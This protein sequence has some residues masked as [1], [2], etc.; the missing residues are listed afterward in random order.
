M[1]IDGHELKKKLRW[2]TILFGKM[3]VLCDNNICFLIKAMTK[4]KI[5]TF[6]S[7]VNYPATGWSIRNLTIIDSA[8]T[9]QSTP[10]THTLTFRITLKHIQ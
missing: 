5:I 1:V 10:H 4:Q 7:V 3:W 8:S 6:K 9:F 2:L